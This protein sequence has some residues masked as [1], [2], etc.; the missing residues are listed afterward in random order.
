[1]MVVVGA[2]CWGLLQ[3]LSPRH[4]LL[5]AVNPAAVPDVLSTAQTLWHGQHEAPQRSWARAVPENALGKPSEPAGTGWWLIS[6]LEAFEEVPRL[7]EITTCLHPMPQF[8]HV[9]PLTSSPPAPAGPAHSSGLGWALG[10]NPAQWGQDGDLSWG[11][12]EATWG[13][14][15]R[16]GG[17]S[18]PIPVTTWFPSCA[19]S[20]K[21]WGTQRPSHPGDGGLSP[22]CQQHGR[23]SHHGGGDR[24]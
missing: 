7:L 10:T 3:P 4:L 15:Q 9:L 8:P 18:S 6:H 17:S 5:Q 19:R 16:Q 23:G 20:T 24:G 2:E 1:M 12:P 21:G 11:F 22:I 14:W 13:G